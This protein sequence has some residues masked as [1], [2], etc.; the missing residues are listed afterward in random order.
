M[1]YKENS[2]LC[3]SNVFQ[4]L[5]IV[6]QCVDAKNASGELYGKFGNEYEQLLRFK[7]RV[8]TLE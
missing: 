8:Q 6:A 2:S 1:G 7:K 3:I 5:N 4:S